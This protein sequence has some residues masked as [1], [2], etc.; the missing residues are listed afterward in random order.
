PSP[1]AVPLLA[2][3]INVLFRPEQEHCSSGEHNVPVPMAR[4]NG[5]V[6]GSFA[7]AK[8]AAAD[9]NW[10]IKIAT[11]ARR[12]DLRILIQAGGN[13]KRI[14]Y[15]IPEPRL[16]PPLD[17]AARRNAENRCS[18]PQLTV[19]LCHEGMALAQARQAVT[20][21]RSGGSQAARHL[22]DGG[23]SLAVQQ[24]AINRK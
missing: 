5:D 9:L 15:A 3:A 8:L 7:S 12:T 14:P 18:P 1:G 24:V 19:L 6:N 4:G 13:A 23:A 22:G 10:H 17:R 21:F 2:P 11:T 20:D 16:L